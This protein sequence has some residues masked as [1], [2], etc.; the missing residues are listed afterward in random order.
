MPEINPSK[1]DVNMTRN[2]SSDAFVIYGL[3]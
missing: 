1:T 2:G 3:R